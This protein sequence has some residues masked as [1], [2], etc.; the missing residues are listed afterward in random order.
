E[1]QRLRLSSPQAGVVL[2]PPNMTRSRN[3]DESLP[4][5]HG[6][7]LDT[8]NLGTTVREQTLFCYVGDPERQDALLLVDQNG[9]EFVRPGQLVRLRFL[10]DPGRVREGRVEEIAS[11]RAEVVPREMTVAQ[12]IPVR[13][14]STGSAPAEVS[15]EVRVRLLT[16]TAEQPSSSGLYSPGHARIA[17]GY[18][19][20]VVRFLRL[21]RTTFSAE[22]SPVD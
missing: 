12:V 13:H 4:E 1:V 2:P 18:Q 3:A 10:S 9:V 17:C 14:T 15:Y 16:E 21:L 20:L 8:D 11:A 6:T 7:P 19:S 5:W 22:L